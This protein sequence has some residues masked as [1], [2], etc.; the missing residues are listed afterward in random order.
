MASLVGPSRA[1]QL[2]I[3][4]GPIDARKAES[5]G[6][7]DEC[8]AK[9]SALDLALVWAERLSALPPVPVRMTK[10][11]INAAT[12]AL[13]RSTSIM[14]RDQWLLTAGTN[15]LAEGVSAFL[16]KRSPEFKGD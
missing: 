10:E 6:L 15:D 8:A 7:I 4:G 5:W 16:E 3:F 1:K 9:G 13:H 12:T 11:A 14:D 2:A